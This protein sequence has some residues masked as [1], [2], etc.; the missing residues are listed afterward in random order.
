MAALPLLAAVAACSEGHSAGGREAPAA[1]VSSG[2]IARVRALRAVFPGLLDA[3]SD[4]GRVDLV[5]TASG[6]VHGEARAGSGA[7]TVELPGDAAGAVRLVDTVS[8]L[9]VGFALE[10]AAPAKVAVVDGIALYEG[11]VAAAG[12]AALDLVHRVHAR[13]TEDFVVFEREPA[14]KQLRYRL[15]V[16]G[17]AGLRLVEGTLEFLDGGG[18]PRLRVAR[19][20]LADA[21][22]RRFPATL[23]VEGCAVDTSPR[24]PWGRPVTAP[25]ASA[26]ALR[27]AWQS[28]EL[29]YP[30]LLDPAWVST[31]ATMVHRRTRHTATAL[32]RVTALDPT[33]SASPV[34]I[35]GGFDETGAAVPVAELYQ[36]QNRIFTVTGR[37]AT[38]R[39]AHTATALTAVVPAP[40]ASAPP[41]LLAGGRTATP[42]GTAISG[43]EIYDF[44]T[45]RFVADAHSLPLGRYDH[46]ATLF[47][48]GAVLLAGGMAGGLDPRLDQPT[49]TAFVYTFTAPGAGGSTLESTANTLQFSRFS[50]AAVRLRTGDVLLT[51]GFVQAGNALTSG[52]LYSASARSFVPITASSLAFST[53]MTALRGFHTATLLDTGEVLI[54]GGTN[55]VQTRDRIYQNTVD[56]YRDGVTDPAAR[57]FERET[58]GIAMSRARTNHTATLL[59]TGQVLIAGGYNEAGAIGIAE[60]YTPTSRQFSVLDV[61]APMAP[62]L[63]HVAVLVNAGGDVTAGRAVLLAGGTAAA[64]GLALDT[65]QLLLKPNGDACTLG[66]ECAT[67]HCTENVCCNE[68]CTQECYS[69]TAVGKGT[70]ADGTCGFSRAGTQ[71]SPSCVNE[72]EIHNQCD[73]AGHATPNPDPAATKDCKPGTC[74][75]N[76]RTCSPYCDETHPCSETGWCDFEAGNGGGGA[77]GGGAGG[78]GAGDS[79]GAGGVAGAGGV[80]GAAGAGGGGGAGDATGGGT[81]VIPPDAGQCKAKFTNSANCVEDRQCTSGSCVDGVCCNQPCQGQCQACDTPNNVGFCITVG[82]AESEAPHPNL[83]GSFQREPCNGTGDCSG[84]C[85]GTNPSACTYPGGNEEDGLPVCSCPDE[86]CAVGPAVEL[87]RICDGNGTSNDSPT[88]CVGFRC[89]DGNTCKSTCVGD[90]DCILD[91]ICESGSCVAL[92]ARSCDGDHTVRVPAADDVDCAPY[93]CASTDCRTECKSVADCVD[94]V[95]NGAGRC[96]PQ[97]EAPEVPSCSCRAPGSAVE[98]D[99]ARWPLLLCVGALG[100]A[101]SRRRRRAPSAAR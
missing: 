90:T 74:D 36:P 22:G 70:G 84:L 12:G 58:I 21:T 89:A 57:G 79:G 49:N 7:A 50:H 11:A 39:G 78:D 34:L 2:A 100:G 69:C 60:L 59:P 76:G 93:R 66:A 67:G 25:G 42:G 51:G 35:A 24:A 83:G 17:V 91:F 77:G 9:A 26:C 80:G 32:A 15:D 30:A 23:D 54:T 99:A 3:P 81:P 14:R 53:Q 55:Q 31:Q 8:Q 46:T 6:A 86:G 87:H 16:S 95:C 27:V 71:L 73:G 47:A 101:A 20:W 61:P 43:L 63:D 40:G 88:P 65:A 33:A 56:I 68:A 28:G 96:V 64:G 1:A 37:M 75:P 29:R 45:G 41:V 48:D 94:A 38:A 52:E 18:I 19:P 44:D 4:D 72:I 5:M 62:R 10:A 97:I 98:G 85:D 13:G 92:T 82:A